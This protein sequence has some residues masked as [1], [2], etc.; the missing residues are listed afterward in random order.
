MSVLALLYPLTRF[1]QR[2][3]GSW[4]SFDEVIDVAADAALEASDDVTFSG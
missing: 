2:D 3:S 1:P 4:L